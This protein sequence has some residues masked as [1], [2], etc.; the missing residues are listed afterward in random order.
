[1]KA[2][3]LMENKVR[4]EQGFVLVIALLVMVALTII[5]IAATSTTTLE[6]NIAGNTKVS[7]INFYTAE[8]A[9]YEGAQRLMNESSESVLLPATN[10]APQPTDFVRTAAA[11]SSPAAVDMANL[12]T[13]GDGSFDLNQSSITV[14][15]TII[16]EV[17]TLNGVKS[18]SSLGMDTSRMYDYSAYGVSQA[19]RGEVIIKVGVKKRF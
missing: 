14:P 12:D 7:K 13:D 19:N 15:N 17:I 8:S 4:D 6:L 10:P 2:S 16:G 1:M 3:F 5:G 18:G 11:V 9:A